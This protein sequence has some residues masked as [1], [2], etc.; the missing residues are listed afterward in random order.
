MPATERPDVRRR[1]SVAR[2]DEPADLV[3]TGGR[4]L[5]VFTGELLEADV[6]ISGGHVAGVGPGYDGIERYT[7][8]ARQRIKPDMEWEIRQAEGKR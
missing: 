2:G 6:A 8:I 3:I 1:L 7:D 4:V 5:S